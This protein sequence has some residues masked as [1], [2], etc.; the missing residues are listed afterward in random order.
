MNNAENW[1]HAWF[2][3]WKETG[4]V[5]KKCPSIHEFIDE[6]VTDY[7]DKD[8]ILEYLEKAQV[9]ATTSR[10]SFP[11]VLTKKKFTGSLSY[12][13]DG[14]WLWPDDLAYYVREHHVRLPVKMLETI[15]L[16]SYTP[17][18]VSLETIQTLERPPIA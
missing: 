6:K 17:P 16:N 9:V 14:I 18:T 1:D 12:R 15:R 5:F 3:V 7:R 13:T 10:L 8:K 2:G 11:C 4:P